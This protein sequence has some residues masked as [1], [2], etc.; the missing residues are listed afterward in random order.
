M[1]MRRIRPKG[2]HVSRYGDD[3]ST[4]SNGPLRYT[5]GWFRGKA[6]SIHSGMVKE[7]TKR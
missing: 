4:Y 7:W 5:H 2:Q 3:L 6:I 1:D